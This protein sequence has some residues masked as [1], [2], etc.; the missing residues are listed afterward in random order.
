VR[1]AAGAG[2]G[3]LLAVLWFDLMFD[4]QARGHRGGALPAQVRDSIASYY[5]RVTTAARPMN[6]LIAAVMVVTVGALVG[7]V[8]EGDVAAWR[9]WLSLALVMVGIVLAAARTV[10]NAVRLG[11]QSDSAVEQ[12]VLARSILR[13]HLVCLAAIAGAL[14]LQLAR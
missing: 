3:F 1:I 11:A 4:V 9:A 5:Q 12:S 13:D 10:R 14:V 8:V 2:T 7:V 6:R